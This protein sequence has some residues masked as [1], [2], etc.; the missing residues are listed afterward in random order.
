MQ[1]LR[2][3]LFPAALILGA[4]L[5]IAGSASAQLVGPGSSSLQTFA[6]LNAGNI[7]ADGSGNISA[8]YVTVDYS[9]TGQPVSTTGGQSFTG[10][11]SAGA[12]QTM[13]LS[14]SA[15]A[16]AGYGV[17]HAYATGTV[18]NPYFNAANK[19]F[20][21]GN[22]PG[23]QNN[24]DGSPQ[25]LE[26]VGQALFSD[27]LTLNPTTDPIVGIRY[28]FHL[29]GSVTDDQR[30]YA[31]LGFSA[32]THQAGFS[33]TG[34]ADWAT[35]TWSVTPGS[36]IPISGNFGAVLQV[37]TND[38][39]TPEGVSVSGTA[40][41]YNTLTISEIDLLDAA[42]NPVTGATYLTAS[43]AQYNIVGATYGPAAVPEPGSMSVFASLLCV[44]A[45]W[46]FKRRRSRA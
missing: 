29:D 39:N 26:A 42:G 34:T 37:N 2:R 41:F 44:G 22:G 30:A 40:D 9:P 32:G 15:Q 6:Y 35:D 38:P 36:P 31:F 23:G 18:D 13:T 33:A 10:L 8:L 20:F 3:R 21:T 46:C 17:L 1:S 16:A 43:G 5:G 14:G 7:S 11:D 27:T 12:L 45:G 25:Y 24:S 4:A 19:P 28:V